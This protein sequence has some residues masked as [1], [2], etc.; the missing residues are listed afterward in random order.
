MAIFSY[1]VNNDGLMEEKDVNVDLVNPQRIYCDSNFI[2]A[3]ADQVICTISV[4][5]DGILTIEH[6]ISVPVI[7]S[8]ALFITKLLNFICVG[9][10]VNAGNT[11]CIYIYNI[12]IDGSL[13]I[14]EDSFTEINQYLTDLYAKDNI[15]YLTQNASGGT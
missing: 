9:F 13:I 12:L 4:D 11:S 7:N 5:V 1:E 3:A 10:W 14:I 2:Y 6:T 8:R 15:L